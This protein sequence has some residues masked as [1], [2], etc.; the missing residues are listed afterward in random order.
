MIAAAKPLG[1]WKRIITISTTAKI[2]LAT[3]LGYAIVATNKGISTTALGA[4]R[5]RAVIYLPLLKS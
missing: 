1:A 5:M 2:V 3:L 4:H